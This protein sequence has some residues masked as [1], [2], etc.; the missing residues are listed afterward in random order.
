M[1]SCLVLTFRKRTYGSPLTSPK[2]TY[3]SPLTSPFKKEVV[4]GCLSPPTLRGSWGG[5]GGLSPT[6]FINCNYNY[7][8]IIIIILYTKNK[9]CNVILWKRTR[10]ILYYFACHFHSCYIYFDFILHATKTKHCDNNIF[11]AYY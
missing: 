8:I 11:A 7:L 5:G 4:G 9:T 6:L 2:R 3:G 1:W 10:H